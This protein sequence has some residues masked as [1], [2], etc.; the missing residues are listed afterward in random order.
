MQNVANCIQ[1]DC[2]LIF[3]AKEYPFVLKLT[4]NNNLI[5][6]KSYCSGLCIEQN[7]VDMKLNTFHLPCK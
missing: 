2:T 7:V 1:N 3:L 4:E 6:Y 5:C